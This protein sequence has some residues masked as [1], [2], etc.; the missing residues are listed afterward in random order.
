MAWQWV[1]GTPDYG[2]GMNYKRVEM[3]VRDP[4][5]TYHLVVTI[6][7]DTNEGG[8]AG[9]AQRIGA[10]HD[11]FTDNGW[12]VFQGIVAAGTVTKELEEI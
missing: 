8:D 6:E 11:L 2:D 1:N 3:T 10:L 4:G 5:C 12:V 9:A 7:D